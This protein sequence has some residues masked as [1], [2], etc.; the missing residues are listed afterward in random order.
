MKVLTKEE[1]FSAI[2]NEPQTFESRVFGGAVT[3]RLAKVGDKAYARKYTTKGGV[4]DSEEFECAI[5][6]RCLI[7][8]QLAEM[9][10]LE[11]YKLNA[12]EVNRLASA[13]LSAGGKVLDPLK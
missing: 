9:D 5:I 13:I 10:I 12:A 8:P 2:N 7:D 6:A 4:L 3:Y 11:L 1:L